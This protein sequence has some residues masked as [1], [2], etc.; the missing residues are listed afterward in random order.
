LL[1]FWHDPGSINDLLIVGPE[2]NTYTPNI[3]KIFA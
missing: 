2:N 3:T 1:E